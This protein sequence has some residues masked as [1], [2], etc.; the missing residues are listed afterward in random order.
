MT[1]IKT[2]LL[3]TLQLVRSFIRTMYDLQDIRIQ[4]SNR[5][6]AGYR[7]RVQQGLRKEMTDEEVEQL[8]NGIM[9]GYESEYKKNMDGRNLKANGELTRSVKPG[10]IIP[11][12]FIR[13]YVD[14]VL[15]AQY[16][17][18]VQAEERQLKML[19]HILEEV[20]LYTNW[21]KNI[22]GVGPLMSAVIVSEIDF[23]KCKYPSSLHR[24]A[25]LD[26]VEVMEVW[27]NG[28]LVDTLKT[29]DARVAHLTHLRPG[30]VS[31]SDDGVTYRC[32]SRGRDR[33]AYSL[34][35][36]S[37][38]GVDGSEEMRK[39]LTFNPRLKTKMVGVLAGNFLKQTKT[40]VCGVPHSKK[41]RISLAAKMG[42]VSTKKGLEEI[43][44]VDAW[45]C[46]NGKEV[47]KQRGHYAQIYADHRTRLANDPSKA[48]M[49]PLHAHNRALRYMIKIFLSD[50]Y[51]EGRKMVGMTV[52]PTYGES[53][54]NLFHGQDPKPT[55]DKDPGFNDPMD[56]M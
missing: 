14:F 13:N 46:E 53:K 25:G 16:A 12:E 17:G 34:I 29:T 42:F 21:L 55:S 22:D 51:V 28:K 33:K 4:S 41:E 9:D 8:N 39:S 37:Y 7:S 52:W 3:E 5:L 18:Y 43:K 26:T 1:Q 31:E 35:D 23:T 24:Y 40:L 19:E 27:K 2:S 10:S 48:W 49:T 44:E 20:P 38:K 54:L 45:L 30:D 11:G 6:L 32:S 50:L 36:V 47:T 56:E 15:Y